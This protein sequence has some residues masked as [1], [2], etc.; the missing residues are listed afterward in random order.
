MIGGKPGISSYNLFAT[1]HAIRQELKTL[2]GNIFG[3]NTAL[4]K[5]SNGD[6]DNTRGTLDYQIGAREVRT[7]RPHQIGKTVSS[8]SGGVGPTS[9]PARTANLLGN[10]YM[11]R[12]DGPGANSRHNFGLD[13]SPN[14]GE[15]YDVYGNLENHVQFLDVTVGKD[16][17][18][19]THLENAAIER[20]GDKANDKIYLQ[21]TYSIF[22][23]LEFPFTEDDVEVFKNG[24]KRYS[25][26]E[27]YILK[28][29]EENFV[30]R[31]MDGSVQ[32]FADKFEAVVG[33]REQYKGS[34]LD[35]WEFMGS[36]YYLNILNGV[37][38]HGIYVENYEGEQRNRT[39]VY[40]TDDIPQSDYVYF[41]DADTISPDKDIKGLL[42]KTNR[43]FYDG[44]IQSLV[45]RFATF[46]KND[47]GKP[48]FLNT[49]TDHTY[50]LSRGR[51]LRKSS[52]T[53]E[54]GYDNPYCRVWTTHYQYSKYKNLIRGKWKDNSGA[55]HY[56]L[57][58]D[59]QLMRPNKGYER[60]KN[61]TSIDTE[62][63]RPIFAP[64]YV[65]K[66]DDVEKAKETVKK[67]MFSIENLAWKDIIPNTT[68]IRK[69]E[70]EKTHEDT[71]FMPTMDL[72]NGNTS[73]ETIT[74][75][76]T[77]GVAKG[78]GMTLT[79]E[80]RGP[81]GGRIMWFPPYNL[82]FSE[83]LHTEWNQNA[84]IGRG[85]K[86]YSY[87]NS[88]RVG[89][90]SFTIL[91]DHPSI[92][93]EWT[94]GGKLGNT[95]NKANPLSKDEMI[96]RYFAGCDSLEF[97]PRG[98]YDVPYS[99]V[100]T[101]SSILTSELVDET[102][103]EQIPV[104]E[105]NEV[106]NDEAAMTF[107]SVFYFPNDYSAAD[108]MGQRVE[109]PN[110]SGTINKDNLSKNQEKGGDAFRQGLAKMFDEGKRS[111]GTGYEMGN[112]SSSTGM[113]YL[114]GG[115]EYFVQ[116][117]SK[118]QKG[119]IHKWYYPVDTRVMNEDLRTPDRYKDMHDFGLNSTLYGDFWSEEKLNEVPEGGMKDYLNKGNT[120]LENSTDEHLKTATGLLAATNGKE[121]K[122]FIPAYNFFKNLGTVVR[123]FEKETG[124]QYKY[125]IDIQGYASQH[126]YSSTA[127]TDNAF[128]IDVSSSGE[129]TEYGE[130]VR[131]NEILAENRAAV[132]EGWIR[133]L[134]IF[135][136]D[137]DGGD[138]I[139]HNGNGH[140]EK[141][142]EG[143]ESDFRPKAARAAVVTFQIIPPKTIMTDVEKQVEI[144]YTDTKLVETREEHHTVEEK[145]DT[146][147]SDDYENQT[148]DN[149]YT[150]FKQISENDD[151]VKRYISDK[152]DYFDPA[153]H[154]ITPEG[155]NARL[156]FLQQCM[157]QGP[158][159][160]ASD[161][162]RGAAYGAG[163]LSFG[164]AP[165]CVL[166]IGDFFNTK[167]CIESIQISYGNNEGMHWDINPEG[168][169]LQP[170]FADVDITFTFLGGSDISGPIA[171]LQNAAS[172]NYYANTSVYD[173]RSDY[174]ETYVT[175]E[176]DSAKS[177]AP[178]LLDQ[179]NNAN[180]TEHFD[181]YTRKP[182]IG[183][184]RK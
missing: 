145:Y 111:V 155:F 56:T 59:D 142:S 158:T 183:E 119:V 84:F 13:G 82:K 14:I 49:A 163:N 44:K 139:S 181:F 89:N 35:M 168:I 96:L 93:N 144:E 90:L 130:N 46:T 172:F 135:D 88:E 173:R 7:I 60:L 21:T 126:G 166:R 112:G 33:G 103:T 78:F 120:S 86:V 156:T 109:K 124:G 176:D 27:P 106:Q 133:N 117:K 171:R 81:N 64:Y 63:G 76:T 104:M 74:K 118:Y 38:E 160:S 72:G 165:F 149:E 138:E 151:L 157:R 16:L 57:H 153:Y 34:L 98:E 52:K 134:G 66:R 80:Q 91:V 61:F 69:D 45:N 108:F 122:Y 31:T 94:R 97:N 6:D 114:T 161:T 43:M 58:S 20:N 162:G 54:N 113:T 18:G 2:G 65:D 180:V 73:T 132:I 175:K 19:Y 148:Y 48:G 116:C 164:R 50:G 9:T 154:S 121:Y 25:P 22:N 87:V 129:I 179:G 99:K 150:Y 131:S 4:M 178:L 85:E 128:K 8:T 137:V 170:M 95:G 77:T 167:I 39:S 182:K 53:T 127:R 42:N 55:E 115:T 100:E 41:L 141:T 47:E 169:G 24:P 92:I 174:R 105:Q 10:P 70:N 15:Y 40:N 143:T 12:Y 123:E 17:F 146:S 147:K 107:Y 75:K 140:V 101:D 1:G 62:N 5:I 51:N 23:D 184:N 136:F 67:C 68:L 29:L 30:R 110:T 37:A 36:H 26:S 11:R 125:K 102:V 83:Q 177:W 32:G 3:T 152:V 71:L 79:P 159:I 28:P